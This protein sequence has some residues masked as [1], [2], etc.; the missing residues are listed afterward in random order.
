MQTSSDKIDESKPFEAIFSSTVLS[1]HLD[2]DDENLQQ[3]N[4][5]DQTIE[6]NVETDNDELIERLRKNLSKPAGIFK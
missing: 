4:E 6:L 5:Q 3:I 2:S 1:I